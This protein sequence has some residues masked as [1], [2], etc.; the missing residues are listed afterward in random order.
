MAAIN[1][2]PKMFKKRPKNDQGKWPKNV[3]INILNYRLVQKSHKH[4]SNTSNTSK[5]NQHWINKSFN[6]F[7]PRIRLITAQCLAECLRQLQLAWVCEPSKGHSLHE[8]KHG[9][10]IWRFCTKN[11][12][13]WYEMLMTIWW[14]FDVY[15][16][17]ICVIES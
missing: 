14:L 1:K 12:T 3:Q 15:L 9:E 4:I 16:M 17:S 5:L 10:R 6:M 13:K 7:Q 11:H 2:C 8:K